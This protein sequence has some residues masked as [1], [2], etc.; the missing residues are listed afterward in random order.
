M[1]M[2]TDTLTSEDFYRAAKHASTFGHGIVYIEDCSRHGSRS[3]KQAFNVKLEGDGTVN[4]RP[5]NSGRCGAHSEG[6]YAASW[7]QWGWF[8]A[9]LYQIDPTMKCWAYE[10]VSDFHEKTKHKF[11]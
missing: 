2:H 10:N 3:R 4:K 6:C 1:R 9:Y 8:F 5:P 11:A 7:D